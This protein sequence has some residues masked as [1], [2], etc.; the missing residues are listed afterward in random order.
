[1]D[2]I[3]KRD[4]E[5][6][7]FAQNLSLYGSLNCSRWLAPNPESMITEPLDDFEAKYNKSKVPNSG[8]VDKRTKNLAKEKLVTAL[9][10]YVQGFVAKNPYVNED[11]KI[12]MRLPVYDK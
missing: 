4:S 2:Y 12:A 10:G 1:M 5:L 9:R 11:D 6:F 3:P 7:D 8:S